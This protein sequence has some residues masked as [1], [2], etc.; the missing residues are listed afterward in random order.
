M[1][2]LDQSEISWL[3]C[4]EQT[5]MGWQYLHICM[6]TTSKQLWRLHSSNDCTWRWDCVT[7]VTIASS[8]IPRWTIALHHTVTAV[9]QLWWSYDGNC[10]MPMA[11]VRH[12]H[13]RQWQTN[14]DS[15]S[16]GYRTNI[17]FH[18]SPQFIQVDWIM[19]M[20]FGTVERCHVA[21]DLVMPEVGSLHII[22]VVLQWPVGVPPPPE[23]LV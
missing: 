11:F 20:I 1:M 10:C 2:P 14:N 19:C 4:V 18:S 15:S 7:V 16:V 6:E 5:F 17:K 12:Q 22:G 8:P 23:M 3:L 21:V 13:W 9:A